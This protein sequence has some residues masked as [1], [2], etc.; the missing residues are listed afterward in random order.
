VPRGRSSSCPRVLG[1][2]ARTRSGRRS[3]P[4]ETRGPCPS[5]RRRRGPRRPAPCP[6]PGD[7]PPVPTPP[8]C[9]RARRAPP[10]S[11]PTPGPSTVDVHSDRARAQAHGRRPGV[12]PRPHP[13]IGGGRRVGPLLLPSV[14]LGLRAGLFSLTDCPRLLASRA[15]ISCRTAPYA[16][17]AA[18]V[19]APQASPAP[20][21]RCASR[22]PITSS[23]RTR[24]RRPTRTRASSAA[25]TRASISCRTAP[26]AAP[27]AAVQARQASPAPRRRCAS[28][29]PI[30]GSF[31]TRC[32]RPA[33]TRASL[34]ASARR[35]LP[36]GNTSVCSRRH[37]R[38]DRASPDPA[39]V[40]VT[41]IQGAGAPGP[42]RG[43]SSAG[44]W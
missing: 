13:Q 22:R 35:V 26:Y 25:A 5:S 12:F 34:S 33:R 7:G 18:A 36:C 11:S 16:A 38:R 37:R 41:A 8:D 27:A 9:G 28:R 17:P 20:R 15:S 31:R 24:C 14:P 10:R 6:P 4:G 43:P 2:R 19:Q 39:G 29:R 3:R 40:A 44:R 32:R 42:L 21:R 30:T 1:R 23:F